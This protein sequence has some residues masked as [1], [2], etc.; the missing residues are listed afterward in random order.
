[1]PNQ[2]NSANDLF[3]AAIYQKKLQD[4]GVFM[5]KHQSLKSLK[6]AT[7]DLLESAIDEKSDQHAEPMH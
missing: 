1:M 6:S 5:Q 4:M 2:R 7:E 3:F